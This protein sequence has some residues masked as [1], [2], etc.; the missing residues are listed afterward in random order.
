MPDKLQ[1]NDLKKKLEWYEEL[2]EED[3]GF[4]LSAMSNIRS[5]RKDVD[6]DDM[7]QTYRERQSD[8][9]EGISIKFMI[10]IAICIAVIELLGYGIIL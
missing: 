3:Q 4:V 2:T 9:S 10:L 6:A 8:D 5:D 7:V 1:S